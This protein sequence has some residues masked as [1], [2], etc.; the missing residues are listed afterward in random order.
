VL[1][2]VKAAV[3]TA[4]AT[5]RILRRRARRLAPQETQQARI[6]TDANQVLGSG[7]EHYEA[8][9]SN[10]KQQ[11]I[12]QN[13][14]QEMNGKYYQNRQLPSGESALVEMKPPPAVVDAEK[15]G[16]AQI[17]NMMFRGLEG[18]TLAL[19]GLRQLLHHALHD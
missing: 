12:K 17:S 6:L 18:E 11:W 2:A 7:G 10:A 8:L 9:G 19:L 16:N 3:P 4:P 14:L 1:P 15:G 13:G 5:Q